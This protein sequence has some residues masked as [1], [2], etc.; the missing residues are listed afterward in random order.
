[1]TELTTRRA[2][3]DDSDAL[4]AIAR[5]AKAHWGYPSDLLDLWGEDLT[6]TPA[7]ITENLVLCAVEDGIIV[8]FA[9]ARPCDDGWELEHLWVMPDHMAHGVGRRLFA[10]VVEALRALGVR[11]LRIVSDPHAEGFYRHMGARVVG[12]V[13][14]TPP[15]RRLPLLTLGIPD[16]RTDGE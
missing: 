5:A 1:M 6:I 12:E 4:T 11:S 8:G 9:A 2:T 15:G 16:T 7:F 3:R 14:S 13:E 10:E